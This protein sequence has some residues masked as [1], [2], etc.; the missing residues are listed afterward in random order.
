EIPD[1][2][3]YCNLCGKSTQTAS[4]STARTAGRLIGRLL[5]ILGVFFIVWTVLRLM[6]GSHTTVRH[7]TQAVEAA[8]RA[9][10][11]LKDEVQNI[12]A[13]SRKGVGLN[14]PYA[15]EVDVDLTV[16]QGNPIDVFVTPSDQLGPMQQWNAL[17]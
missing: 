14:I 13:S 5:P 8:V 16:V 17:K 4:P 9:P 1:G 3:A 2:S 10:I 6:N 12:P 7:A 11:T 15:G